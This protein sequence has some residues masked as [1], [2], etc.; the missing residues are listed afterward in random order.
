MVWEKHS[1][2]MI[3]NIEHSLVILKEN[4]NRVVLETAA[5]WTLGL[6]PVGN[7][8]VSRTLKRLL[9]FVNK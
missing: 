8:C 2:V 9:K 6:L 4:A 1:V 5:S 7:S 3:L